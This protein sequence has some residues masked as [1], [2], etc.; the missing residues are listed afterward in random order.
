MD[1]CTGVLSP[2]TLTPRR[3]PSLLNGATLGGRSA[4]AHGT[5]HCSPL[6]DLLADQTSRCLP[7]QIA[8][9]LAGGVWIIA[10]LF[11]YGWLS[12]TK[13]DG[14]DWDMIDP[15]T[16][17]HAAALQRDARVSLVI[18]TTAGVV[19]M[20]A[21]GVCRTSW[22]R[23]LLLTL[24]LLYSAAVVPLAAC[25]IR[26]ASTASPVYAALALILGLLLLNASRRH[27]TAVSATTPRQ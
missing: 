25:A 2:A 22:G 7:P 20:A 10:A 5:I 11:L 16:P 14:V 26:D 6:W 27:R 18:G 8:L 3:G 19:Q 1:R 15:I 4:I 24:G 9:L 23:W 21:A 17:E 13:I 12:P